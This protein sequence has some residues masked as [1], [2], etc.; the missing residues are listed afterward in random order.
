M[1]FVRKTDI[2]YKKIQILY[3][4]NYLVFKYILNIDAQNPQKHKNQP[5]FLR[6]VL[7]SIFTSVYN[8]EKSIKNR[9]FVPT[10]LPTT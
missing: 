4:Y 9:T 10:I 6:G 8:L 5:L 7:F 1:H 3:A 2:P